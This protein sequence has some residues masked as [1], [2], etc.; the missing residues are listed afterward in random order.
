M[1]K[2]EERRTKNKERRT[3]NEERN[4]GTSEL[5]TSKPRNLGT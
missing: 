1:V 2:R 3:K 5:E 4:V